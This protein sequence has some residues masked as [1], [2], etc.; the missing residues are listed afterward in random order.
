VKTDIIIQPTRFNIVEEAGCSATD[1]SYVGYIIYIGPLFVSSLGCAILAPLTLRTFFRHR[2]EMNEFLSSSQVVTRNKYN[3]LMVIACLDTIL[4]LPMDI[5]GIV[6]SILPGKDNSLNYPY[7]SWKNVLDGVGGN[8]PGLSLS[9]IQQTPASEW[10][11]DTWTVLTIKWDEW[12][13]VLEA[14]IFFGIFGTT[15]EMRRYLRCA[16]WFIPECCGYKRKRASDVETV[17]D[18]AFNSNPGQ[19]M[20]NR[21]A[22][23]RR[24]GSLSFLETTIDTSTSHSEEMAE[25][26]DL[27]LGVMPAGAQRAI[28]IVEGDEKHA[29]GGI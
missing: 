6:M 27:E 29:V 12:V 7:I 5:A 21:P 4:N 19:Q 17:S 15:P 25:G 23:N 1:Y 26:N 3:R 18:V 16:F 11:T 10:G 2:K 8:I 13:F 28:E 14:L 20:G 9:S 24:R 22:V